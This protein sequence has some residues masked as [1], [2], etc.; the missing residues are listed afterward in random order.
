MTIATVQAVSGRFLSSSDP[1]VLAIKGAWG[2]GKTYAWRKIVANNHE[3][4]GLKDYCYVSLFGISSIPEL[5]LSIFAKTRKFE[6]IGTKPDIKSLAKGWL[7]TLLKKFDIPYLKNVSVGLEQ[8]AP[9][10]IKDTV[11]CLDDFERSIKPTA[12][13]ILGFISYL[14]EECNCKIVLIFNEDRLGEKV[15]VYERYREKVVDI[16][17]LFS[18]SSEEAVQWAFPANMPSRQ[19]AEDCVLSLEIANIRLLKKIADLI[20]LLHPHLESFHPNVMQQAV[21]T[22]VLFAWA[23]YDKNEDKPDYKFIRDWDVFKWVSKEGKSEKDQ[24]T[25]KWAAVLRNYGLGSIDEFDLAISKVIEHGHIEETGL[26]AE[27]T[28]LDARFKANEL[29]HSF[30]KAWELFHNS[31]ENNAEELVTAL[32]ESFKRAYSQ[33]SPT[34]LNSTVRLFRRLGHNDEAN[35]LIEF[36]IEH[37]AE[38]HSLFDLER[39]PFASNIDDKT[40]QDRFKEVVTAQS[41][42][43]NLLDTVRTVAKN[44]GW[45][46]EQIQVI[47]QATVDDYYN[48][49][50]ENQGEDL[51]LVIQSCLWFETVSGMKH[52]TEKPRAALERIGRL[53]VL[54]ALRVMNFGVL[55]KDDEGEPAKSN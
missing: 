11:I 47:E 7:P 48:L 23:Y 51:V 8:I 46:P 40:L 54:N 12:E 34:N 29:E 1:Q 33:I 16:E 3:P 25:E 22:A 19:Q 2:V 26:L 43:L 5:A 37:R 31:F 9:Y 24:K 14:K 13:E 53:S 38:E 42:P 36:Y 50:M 4:T 15:E 32:K 41:P 17:L 49:F 20:T 10:V 21:A 35:E 6:Q 39:F 27:A 18:P 44:R 52:L 28:Q 45:S 30:S 55:I